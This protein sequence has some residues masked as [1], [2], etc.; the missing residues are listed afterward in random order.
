[1]LLSLKLKK[2]LSILL[3]FIL[4]TNTYADF[5]ECN[6]NYTI[7]G[8]TYTFSWSTSNGDCNNPTDGLA[9]YTGTLNGEIIDEG[10]MYSSDAVNQIGLFGGGGRE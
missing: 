1:M 2:N 4:V 8:I 9:Y 5:T 7:H 10:Y 3:L 6:G